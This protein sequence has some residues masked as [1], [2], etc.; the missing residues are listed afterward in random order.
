MQNLQKTG[1]GVPIMVNQVL[2]TS[3]LPSS[4]RS[5]SLRLCGCPVF[6]SPYSLPSSVSCNSFVCHSYE[7]W[8]G[9]YPKFPVWKR[10]PC[11]SWFASLARENKKRAQHAAPSQEDSEI[12]I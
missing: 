9:V 10:A 5:V 12:R 8:R 4:P 6:H 1:G 3:R 2:E 7:N 11:S